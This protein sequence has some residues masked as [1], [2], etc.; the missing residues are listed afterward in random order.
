MLRGLIG[1]IYVKDHFTLLQDKY[2]QGLDWQ[3]LCIGPL[4]IA[5]G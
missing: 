2:A 3:N 1:S 5:T 4:Y